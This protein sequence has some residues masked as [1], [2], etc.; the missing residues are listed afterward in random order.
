MCVCVNVCTYPSMWVSMYVGKVFTKYWM[1]KQDPTRQS[2]AVGMCGTGTGRGEGGKARDG[3]GG[4]MA[5]LT[6]AYMPFKKY[7]N[8]KKYKITVA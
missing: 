4:E 6:G 1:C 7:K 2:S 8:I 5:Q 3:G